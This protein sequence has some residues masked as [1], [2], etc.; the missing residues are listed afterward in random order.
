MLTKFGDWFCKHE[1]TSSQR[2]PFPDASLQCSDL[3]AGEGTRAL[4][5]K[6]GEELATKVHEQ[7]KDYRVPMM[8]DLAVPSYF[9]PVAVSAAAEPPKPDVAPTKVDKKKRKK[10]K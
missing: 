7:F 10:K 4:L 3:T 1:T 9:P 6:S 8:L 5:S 2:A